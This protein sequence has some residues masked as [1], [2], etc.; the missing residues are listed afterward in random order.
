MNNNNFS[1]VEDRYEKLLV[2]G[3][4]A[5]AVAKCDYDGNIFKGN[6]PDGWVEIRN[7]LDSKWAWHGETK[8]IDGKLFGKIKS[9]KG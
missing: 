8:L 3:N 7:D 1:I 5:N 4:I 9:K 2:F 6:H